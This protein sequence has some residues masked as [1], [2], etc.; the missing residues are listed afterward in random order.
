MGSGSEDYE[1]WLVQSWGTHTTVRER[2][3]GN[4]LM[5]QCTKEERKRTMLITGKECSRKKRQ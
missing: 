5:K 4:I 1:M 3:M 2:L